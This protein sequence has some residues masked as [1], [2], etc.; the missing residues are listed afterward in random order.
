[1]STKTRNKS[2]SEPD[3]ALKSNGRTCQDGP[4]RPTLSAPSLDPLESTE[5]DSQPP[6]WVSVFRAQ[7]AE[8]IEEKFNIRL[9][10]LQYDPGIRLS[11][12]EKH[13]SDIEVKQGH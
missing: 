7:L 8:D 10:A 12:L 4:K 2:K 11:S 3:A 5:N 9:D 6:A 13:V 1:M